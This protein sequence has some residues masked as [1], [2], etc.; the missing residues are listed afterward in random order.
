MK[1][2]E[3]GIEMRYRLHG[4]PGG[5]PLLLLHGF[6]GSGATWSTI[7]GDL[8]ALGPRYRLVIPDLRGHGGSTNPPGEFTLRQSS[9]DVLALLDHLGI[10]RCRVIGMSGGGMTALHMA[11]AEP[12][13]VERLVLISATTHFPEQARVIM[14]GMTEETRTED[15][16][17]QMRALHVHGDDQIRA[18]WRIARGFADSHDDMAFTAADLARITAPTLIVHGDRDPFF[19]LDIALAMHDAIPRGWLW[20]VPNGGHLTIAG[21]GLTDGFV[22]TAT[23]FLAGEWE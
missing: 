16:W 14:R 3:N 8:D 12:R 21:E 4:D 11:V 7:L 1:L 9:R 6:L 20:V 10:E 19:P 5:E 23:A 15:E 18:L 17:A 13:R 22:R 2:I